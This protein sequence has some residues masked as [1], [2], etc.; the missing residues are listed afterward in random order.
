MMFEPD[1][2]L[3]WSLYA[4]MVGVVWLLGIRGWRQELKYGTKQGGE[5]FDVGMTICMVGVFWLPVIVLGLIILGLKQTVKLC[6]FMFSIE[7]MKQG[8]KQ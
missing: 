3:V 7:L 2:I 6:K 4:S 5:P 8:A 1:M